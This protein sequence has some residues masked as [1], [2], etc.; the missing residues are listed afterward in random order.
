MKIENDSVKDYI[1]ELRIN[2]DPKKET[3][4][5]FHYHGTKSGDKFEY[6]VYFDNYRCEWTDEKR[7]FQGFVIENI[8]KF[9]TKS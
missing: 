3:R 1:E 9:L 2:W 4:T 5:G 8:N 7:A 6:E